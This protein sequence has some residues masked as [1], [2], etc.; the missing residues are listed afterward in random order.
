MRTMI[1][2]VNSEFPGLD[3]VPIL[4]L[5][6]VKLPLEWPPNVTSRMAGRFEPR[7]SFT[8]QHQPNWQSTFN[9]NVT[10][11]LNFEI[12]FEFRQHISTKINFWYLAKNP[13]SQRI[14]SDNLKLCIFTQF[15]QNWQIQSKWTGFWAEFSATILL[16]NS[17][18]FLVSNCLNSVKKI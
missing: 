6:M 1:C 16:L 11:S 15:T 9:Q 10:N 7:T 18:E 12:T 13:N 5:V 8:T 14:K 3:L 17:A 2:R 4:H